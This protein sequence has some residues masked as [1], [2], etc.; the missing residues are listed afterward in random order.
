MHFLTVNLIH[1]SHQ[2]SPHLLHLSFLTTSPPNLHS[3]LILALTL[4]FVSIYSLSPFAY[5][6]SIISLFVIT[7]PFYSITHPITKIASMPLQSIATFLILIERC[8]IIIVGWPMT[9][10][11]SHALLRL[12]KIAH[13]LSILLLCLTLC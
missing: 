2:H 12:L 4:H 7:L 6:T 10:C 5:S 8:F 1:H 3:Q 11:Y 9:K 13:S